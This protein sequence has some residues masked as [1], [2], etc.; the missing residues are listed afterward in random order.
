MDDLLF[1]GIGRNYQ[2]CA[3]S[4]DSG[5]N[6]DEG[7]NAGRAAMST[8]QAEQFKVPVRYQEPSLILV[9]QLVISFQPAPGLAEVSRHWFFSR[10]VRTHVHAVDATFV[11]AKRL[12]TGIESRQERSDT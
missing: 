4:T 7:C 9:G 5:T 8:R 12:A 6:A 11:A 3:G 10:P 2:R 1:D